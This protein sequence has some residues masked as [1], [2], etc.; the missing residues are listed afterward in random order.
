MTTAVGNLTQGIRNH[1]GLTVMWMFTVILSVIAGLTILVDSPGETILVPTDP[2]TNQ[3]ISTLPLPTIV[4]GTF[5]APQ[6]VMGTPTGIEQSSDGVTYLRFED[7]F[8][9]ALTHNPN[10]FL[11]KRSL[12]QLSPESDRIVS[13]GIPSDVNFHPCPPGP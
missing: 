6:V 11:G 5:T 8:L 1:P 2:I 9:L 3:P 12:I 4:C 10:L 7:N 13:Y